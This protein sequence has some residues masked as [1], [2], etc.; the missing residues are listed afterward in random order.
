MRVG[1]LTTAM[2]SSLA[3][4]NRATH[5]VEQIAD[6]VARGIEH[7]S[8]DFTRALTQLPVE[9]MHLRANVTVLRA[10][11]VLFEELSRLQRR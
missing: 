1:N 9:K 2:H 3:G 8:G 6:T 10:T 11:D 7:S 5:R 4:I